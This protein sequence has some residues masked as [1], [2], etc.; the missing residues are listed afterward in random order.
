MLITSSTTITQV[1]WGLIYTFI[2]KMLYKLHLLL[3]K[4]NFVVDNL[5]H[6]VNY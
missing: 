1:Y 3:Y 6:L 5:V 4:V 2:I